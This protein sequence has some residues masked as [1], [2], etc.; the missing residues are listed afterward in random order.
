MEERHLKE[1]CLKSPASP[2][3]KEPVGPGCTLPQASSTLT[4]PLNT[5]GLTQ[6]FPN[7]SSSLRTKGVKTSV[8]FFSR[9]D[10]TKPTRTQISLP[11]KQITLSHP[12]SCWAFTDPCVPRKATHA[13]LQALGDHSI[14]CT[15]AESKGG[16]KL[17]RESRTNCLRKCKNMVQRFKKKQVLKKKQPLC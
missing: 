14:V 13:V 11:Q 2:L 5:H 12:S 6:P 8:I 16:T 17:K 3:W 15:E 1:K 7:S 4:A 9:M 10:K